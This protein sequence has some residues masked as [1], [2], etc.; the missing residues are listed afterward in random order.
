MKSFPGISTLSMQLWP[1]CGYT[2]LQWAASGISQ[3]QHRHTAVSADS[4]R[5]HP[6]PWASLLIFSD[7]I[8]RSRGVCGEV[9]PQGRWPATIITYL[10]TETAD[11]HLAVPQLPADR[12]ARGN[13]VTAVPQP[14]PTDIR[15][16]LP[17]LA[18]PQALAEALWGTWGRLSAPL[19]LLM[20]FSR[21]S[22]K[23]QGVARL[24]VDSSLSPCQRRP[25]M[26]SAWWVRLN[27]GLFFPSER[28][29]TFDVVN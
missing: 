20:R 28:K 10:S 5:G 17:P 14:F 4:P 13:R 16:N 6:M 23:Q 15:L 12:Q 8:K 24:G 19:F 22:G 21:L 1:P 25:G 2:A 29:N 26:L 7:E 11:A 9:G 27:A 3:H 18:P